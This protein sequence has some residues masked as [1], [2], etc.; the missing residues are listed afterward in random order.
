MAGRTI[1]SLEK[2][3]ETGWPRRPLVKYFK[4]NRLNSRCGGVQ[5]AVVLVNHHNGREDI[6]QREFVDS[7]R[8]N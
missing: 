6:L 4:I 8:Y 1:F 5:L 7:C 3:I 2:T